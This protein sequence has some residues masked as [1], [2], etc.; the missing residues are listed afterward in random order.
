MTSLQSLWEPKQRLKPLTLGGTY[1]H[2]GYLNMLL[3]I[4]L[5]RCLLFREKNSTW[6]HIMTPQRWHHNPPLFPVSM[7]TSC[8]NPTSSST[9][10][11]RPRMLLA[12]KCSTF[13]RKNTMESLGFE[14]I[15]QRFSDVWNTKH[16][17]QF[18]I[19]KALNRHPQYIK[20][21]SCVEPMFFSRGKKNNVKAALHDFTVDYTQWFGQPKWMWSNRT[22]WAPVPVVWR[23]GEE[24][25]VCHVF[26]LDGFNF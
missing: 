14:W 2:F 10:S 25:E 13:K 26:L 23:G 21:S 22:W 16:V 1:F 18:F 20:D 15:W 17:F 24:M 12:K 9:S 19:I 4:S 6:I 7:A 11:R 5:T 3:I 8:K